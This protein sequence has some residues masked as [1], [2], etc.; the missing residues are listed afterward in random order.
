MGTLREANSQMFK[1]LHETKSELE[2]IKIELTRL[3]HSGS[4]DY[5]P[6]MLSGR[7]VW[8]CNLKIMPSLWDQVTNCCAIHYVYRY[9]ARD[10]GRE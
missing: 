8:F 5:Q 7:S 10:E 3:K 1:E 9:R 4:S 2:S 6:G